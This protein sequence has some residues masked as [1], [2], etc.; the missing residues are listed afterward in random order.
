MKITMTNMG[1]RRRLRYRTLG[2]DR[3]SARLGLLI[4]LALLTLSLGTHF[5][6]GPRVAGY[7]EPAD[8]ADLAWQEEVPSARELYPLALAEAKEWLPLAYLVYV[9]LALRPADSYFFA[10]ATPLEPNRSLLVYVEPLEDGYAVR[11]EVAYAPSLTYDSLEPAIDEGD[12]PVDSPDAF[13]IALLNGG[14]DFLREHPSASR[15]WMQLSHFRGKLQW[16]VVFANEDPR[17]GPH[18]DIFI[19]P[20]TGAVLEVEV[21]TE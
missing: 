12:W 13:K 14:E 2:P 21:E 11:S 9:D 20:K 16:R 17:L 3:A 19:D 15:W 8:L 10:F 1:P 5:L 7:D 4:V 18:F 6:L